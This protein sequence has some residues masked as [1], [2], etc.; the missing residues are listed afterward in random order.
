MSN[1]TDKYF[2]VLGICI[3]TLVFCSFFFLQ[4]QVAGDSITYLNAIDFLKTGKTGENFMP[5][6][7]I[8]NFG[9]L[10]VIISLSKIFGSTTGVW[11]ALNAAFYAVS[12]FIFYK[13]LLL[14][15]ENNK[16]A[17]LGTLFLSGNYSFIWFGPNFLMDVGGW[18]FYI[19]SLLFT[20]RY[21]KFNNRKDLLLASLSVGMGGL[22]KEYALLGIIPIFAFLVYENRKDFAVMAKKGI[23]PVILCFLPIVIVYAYAYFRLEY[24][25]FDWFGVALEK[26][27][28]KSRIIE[29][30]KS[31]GSLL[32]FLGILF[33]AGLWTFWRQIKI[34][35]RKIEV[36][37]LSTVASVLP[38]F[39]WPAITQRVLFITVPA[40]IIIACFFFKKYE[41]YFHW[42]IPI[43]TVYVLASFFM[44]LFILDFVN[45]PM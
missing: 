15:F 2:L 21:S 8:T 22:F 5:N 1:K 34:L 41:N 25:Y 14:I 31:F 39:L 13:L 32:N 20:F 19:I 3:I 28:Y 12:S 23:L 26:Y 11:L 17:F 45:L 43:L 44:D 35:D 7:I 42:Y 36:F 40:V 18:M 4:P 16:T 9:A 10:Y 38:A 6:R 29:Y 24:T 37:V 27:E 30:I 33:I